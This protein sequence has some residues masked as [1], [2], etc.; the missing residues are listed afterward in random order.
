MAKNLARKEKEG[1]M[2]LI[3]VLLAVVA[4]FLA[5]ALA[6][7]SQPKRFGLA[8]AEAAMR[9]AGDNPAETAR[10]AKVVVDI[11]GLRDTVAEDVQKQI[12]EADEASA[13]RDEEAEEA[14]AQIAALEAQIA[15]LRRADEDG[16]ART[17]KVRSVGRLFA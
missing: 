11:L 9:R 5:I 10:V 4:L 2:T 3:V 12:A 13:K 14:K 15:D 16:L 6:K 7:K 17:Q 1:V 8:E